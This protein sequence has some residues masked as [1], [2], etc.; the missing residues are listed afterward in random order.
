MVEFL[1]FVFLLITIRIWLPLLIGLVLIALAIG[2]AVGVI[3]VASM[4]PEQAAVFVG[5]FVV[6]LALAL[7]IKW[8]EDTHTVYLRNRRVKNFVRCLP[9]VAVRI[10]R[11]RLRAPDRVAV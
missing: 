6:L 4:Y 2:P 5:L 10:R 3:V 7:L 9:P 11:P 8:A 1:T